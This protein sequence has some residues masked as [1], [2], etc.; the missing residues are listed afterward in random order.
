MERR[1]IRHFMVHG[2][3]RPDGRVY[4]LGA[5]QLPEKDFVLRRSTWPDFPAPRVHDS[6]RA[7]GGY[8]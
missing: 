3:R 6:D 7:M 5:I 8:I 2:L 1:C 4:L